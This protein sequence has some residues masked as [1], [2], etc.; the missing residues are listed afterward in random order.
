MRPANSSLYVFRARIVPLV[1]SYDRRD[2]P[3]LTVPWRTEHPVVV[4]KEAESP[5]GRAVVG[6]RQQRKLHGIVDVDEY[7]ELVMNASCRARET[8]DPGGMTD[9]E[10]SAG[11]MSRHRPWRGRPDVPRRLVTNEQCFSRRIDDW[12]VGE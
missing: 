2:L 9:D 7:L 6:Q 8:G 4:G 11:A 12:V 5:R 3:G 10:L 1:E